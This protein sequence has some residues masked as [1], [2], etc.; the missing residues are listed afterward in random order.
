MPAAWS[1]SKCP[2]RPYLKVSHVLWRKIRDW[3]LFSYTEL[4]KQ[5]V[6]LIDDGG[7]AVT[8]ISGNEHQLRRATG[9]DLV[10][11]ASKD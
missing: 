9:Y 11:L 1:T 10:Q 2:K 6:E 3:W 7:L 8:R 4:H 5:F